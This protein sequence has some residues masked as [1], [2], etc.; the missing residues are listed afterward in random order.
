VRGLREAAEAIANAAAP[1]SASVV[2]QFHPLPPPPTAGPCWAVDGSHAI[3]VDNGA[4]WVVATRVA[5]VAWPGPRRIPADPAL[6]VARPDQAEAQVEKIAARFGVEAPQ[7]RS[8]EA[9][10]AFVRAAAEAEV[11]IQAARQAGAGGLLLVDGALRGLPPV[12]QALADRVVEAAA[13]AGA[14]VVGV[15]K[16][17]AVADED[18][19][20]VQ[21][22]Q[23]SGPAGR[24]AIELEPGVFVARLHPRARH[25]FRIDAPDLAALARVAAFCDDA[26]Y[27]GYPYPLALAHNAV[28]ITGQE[29]RDLAARLADEVRRV[30]GAEA[31]AAL[32]DFHEVLD[33]NL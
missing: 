6:H 18:G 4:L 31:A 1:S 27:T 2:R 25:A 32:R 28:A 30:G 26:V 17:S 19:P 23:E 5:A 8:A 3:L 9:F 22:L 13:R 21:R 15:S 20:L 29:T 10:A 24:W 11:A 33:T 16:R 7:V 14:A 12:P